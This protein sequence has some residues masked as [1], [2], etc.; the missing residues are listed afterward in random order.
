MRKKRPSGWQ[1][2]VLLF[3]S[4]MI[5]GCEFDVTGPTY[6]EK[7]IIQTLEQYGITAH[8]PNAQGE[9][10]VLTKATGE[11]SLLQ[12]DYIDQYEVKGGWVEVFLYADPKTA[13]QEA[14][15]IRRDFD[16]RFRFEQKVAKLQGRT[17]EAAPLP[18]FQHG[19]AIIFG[20]GIS[21]NEE[22]ME[23]INVIF[24]QYKED[25]KQ[26]ETLDEEK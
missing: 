23:R 9:S 13:Y 5:V 8:Y 21:G 16:E 14:L 10:Q 4:S 7:S 22:A 20:G 2:L 3:I 1:L 15:Q 24:G 25:L 17:L 12:V 11:R 19:N 26:N 6:S 18:L